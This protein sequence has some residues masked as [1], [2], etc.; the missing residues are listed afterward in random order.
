MVATKSRKQSRT[1]FALSYVSLVPLIPGFTIPSCNNYSWHD[2]KS[3]SSQK[4]S[5]HNPALRTIAARFAKLNYYIELLHYENCHY[6]EIT[7]AGDTMPT[8][9]ILNLEGIVEN[10]DIPIVV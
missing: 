10:K 6:D 4:L 1:Y 2:L 8:L 3:F 5:F 9:P 7:S